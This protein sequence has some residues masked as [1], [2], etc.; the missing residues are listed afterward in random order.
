MKWTE[1]ASERIVGRESR[2]MVREKRDE[3]GERKAQLTYSGKTLGGLGDFLGES[4]P[5]SSSFCCQLSLL[6]SECPQSFLFQVCTLPLF[7]GN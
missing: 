1:K 7:W 5:P 6:F 3:Q 4:C 2:R